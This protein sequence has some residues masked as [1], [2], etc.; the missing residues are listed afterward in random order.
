MLRLGQRQIAR[1]DKRIFPIAFAGIIVFAFSNLYKTHRTIEVDRAL[2]GAA[3]LKKTDFSLLFVSSIE[4]QLKQ[5]SA[6]AITLIF[7][8][9]TQ[10]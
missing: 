8:A 3:N 4:Q 2:I 1:H 6:V 9:Y 5:F 10:C 7:R